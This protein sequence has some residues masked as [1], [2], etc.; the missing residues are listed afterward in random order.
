MPVDWRVV[1]DGV[2]GLSPCAGAYTTAL[3]RRS[4]PPLVELEAAAERLHL[5]LE[6]LDLNGY[7]RRFYNQV[8][9]EFEVKLV[10][11]RVGPLRARRRAY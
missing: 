3:S 7:S 8:V 6:V 2:A 1:P 10:E 4:G 11:C 5:H 9:H